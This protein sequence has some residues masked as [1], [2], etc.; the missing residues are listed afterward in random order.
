SLCVALYTVYV[1]E[2]E[3]AAARAEKARFRKVAFGEV[4]QGLYHLIDVLRYAALLPYTT[5]PRIASKAPQERPFPELQ[6]QPGYDIDLRSKDALSVL[7]NLYLTPRA[8]LKSPYVPSY[9]PFGTDII[10]SS[11]TV[12]SEESLKAAQLMETAIQKYAAIALPV[13]VIESAS[14]VRQ[15]SFLAHLISLR[16]SWEKRSAMEDSDSPTT[17]NFR[18]L[19]SGLSGGSTQD[20]LHLLENLDQLQTALGK[21]K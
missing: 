3:L 16:E 19:N 11:M 15:S 5:T 17:L 13:D 4:G 9:V 8:H 20:Y 14:A 10:R 1:R 7:E 12:I 21:A 18:L 2:M 6:G